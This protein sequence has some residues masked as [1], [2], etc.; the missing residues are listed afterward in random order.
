MKNILSLQSFARL[1]LCA[2]LGAV[3]VAIPALAQENTGSIR[4]TIKDTT[5]AVIAG[6]K[7]TVSSPTLVRPLDAIT[8][9]DG[10]YR[11]PKLPVGLYVITVGQTGFKTVK[12]EDINL[13]LGSE[14][15]L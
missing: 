15:T 7:V 13:V 14:L 5:G 8:D 1:M 11:F 9:K 2:L 4:G 3:F 6:A 10:V 12:D